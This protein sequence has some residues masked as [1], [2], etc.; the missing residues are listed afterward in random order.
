MIQ[1]IKDVLQKSWI[2]K[3]FLVFLAM[4]FGIWG[5]GDF[6]TPG[7]DPR[8]ALSV[9]KREIKLDEVQRL[10]QPVAGTFGPAPLPEE[11]VGGQQVVWI[12][13]PGGRTLTWMWRVRPGYSPGTMV[14]RL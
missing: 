13:P 9:G 3:V 6:L 7:M 5:I 14:S 2:I 11:L 4:S 10:P 8:I 12:R 1:W